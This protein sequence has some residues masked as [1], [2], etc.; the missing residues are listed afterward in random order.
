MENN[1]LGT[2]E[3]L[4]INGLGIVGQQVAANFQLSCGAADCKPN[5]LLHR[6]TLLALPRGVWPEV[7]VH[8]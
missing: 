8:C 2:G 4:N 7:R 5:A 3:H 6:R 1:H